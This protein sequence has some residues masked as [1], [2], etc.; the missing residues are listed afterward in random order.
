MKTEFRAETVQRSCLV[1]GTCQM[2]AVTALNIVHRGLV[3]R[4]SC[5]PEKLGCDQEGENEKYSCKT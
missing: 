2:S 1:E 4:P 5:V 3:L